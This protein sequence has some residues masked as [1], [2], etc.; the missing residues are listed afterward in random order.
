MPV[1]TSRPGSY[2]GGRAMKRSS[3]RLR[4]T[5]AAL[6]QLL[7]AAYPKLRQPPDVIV[8]NEV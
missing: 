4:A 1:A 8:V 6:L 7:T 5:G 3:L 2:R